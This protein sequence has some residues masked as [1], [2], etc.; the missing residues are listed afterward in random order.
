M[1]PALRSGCASKP[2]APATFVRRAGGP[3]SQLQRERHRGRFAFSE[4]VGQARVQ[5][6]ASAMSSPKV[7]RIELRLCVREKVGPGEGVRTR[8]WGNPG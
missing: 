1:R 7:V 3:R 6:T 2:G 5:L 4:T 8:E